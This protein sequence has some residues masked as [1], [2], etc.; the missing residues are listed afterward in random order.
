MALTA[1]T[2]FERVFLRVSGG[3]SE[4]QS[5]IYRTAIEA[6][7][8]DA[9]HGFCVESLTEP[10]RAHLEADYGLTLSSGVASFAGQTALLAESII[11][12]NYITHPSVTGPTG[13]LLPFHLKPSRESLNLA[14]AD[15]SSIFGYAYVSKTAV[16][17]AFQG[18]AMTGT[19]TVRGISVPA[20][21]SVP[22]VLEPRL[23]EVGVRLAIGKVARL[24]QQQTA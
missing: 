21:A 20:I 23:I 5:G 22:V 9:L 18:A 13:L 6:T 3:V 12:C 16:E 14:V 11:A 15:S 2:Y 1:A 8:G 17:A 24:S 10:W 19:L 4:S 7:M